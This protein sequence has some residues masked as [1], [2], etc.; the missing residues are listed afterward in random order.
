MQ[1]FNF[2]KKFGQNFLNNN[3]IIDTI[4][5]SISPS[6]ND[7]IIEIGPVAGALTK[8]LKK[9][10]SILIAYEVDIDTKKYLNSLEDDK[11]KIIYEDFLDSNI[12]EV[13]K[14]YKYDNLYIIGNLPYYITTKIISHIIELNINPKEMVFMVQKEVADRFMAIPG[15]KEYGYMTVI[16]N[17]NY[18]LKK[19]ID[20]P[21]HN[22]TPVPKVDSSVIKL[23]SK[24][25]NNDINYKLFDNFIKS[26]FKFKRKT[27]KNNLT[28]YNEETL[29]KILSKYNLT[30]S[31]RPEDIPLDAYID[32][33]LNK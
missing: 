8:K 6:S 29:N 10:N 7:L 12:K 20:V 19:V 4:V 1:N 25:T 31:S 32:L 5:E 13:I 11:C 2:K 33:F 24:K 14:K 3:S 26:A 16:L 21:K 30:S 28:N 15:N 9:Y 22:F 17:Y 18:N 27:I 23:I